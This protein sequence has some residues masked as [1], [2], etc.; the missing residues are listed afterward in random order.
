MKN[1]ANRAKT[2]GMS[3][4]ISFKAASDSKTRSDNL[5]YALMVQSDCKFRSKSVDWSQ[6]R[7][8]NRSEICISHCEQVAMTETFT[9]DFL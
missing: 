1:T 8:P 7:L 6:F 9:G 4:V 5:L 3:E 2:G